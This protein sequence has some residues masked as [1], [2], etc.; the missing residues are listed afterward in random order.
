MRDVQILEARG[1]AKRWLLGIHSASGVLGLTLLDTEDDRSHRESRWMLDRDLV[2]RF[3]L[4]LQDFLPPVTWSELAAIAVAIG[5]GSFT[6]CRLGVTVARSLGQTL[7]IPVFGISSLAAIAH[8][9]LFATSLTTRRQPLVSRSFISVA[10][11]M[12]ARRGEW[13]GGIYTRDDDGLHV[14]EADRLWT[15]EAW[16]DRAAGID[17]VDAAEFETLSA[18]LAMTQLAGQQYRQGERPPWHAVE[19]AYIRQPPI[20]RGSQTR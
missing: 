8:A 6:S 5:P 18:A 16:R 17:L 7:D 11:Q 15:D 20:H 12:D 19:P 13:Y 9:S 14:V 3:H 2:A 10:V 4:C 1:C